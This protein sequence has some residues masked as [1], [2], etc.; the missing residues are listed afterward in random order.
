MGRRFITDVYDGGDQHDFVEVDEDG[1]TTGTV[2]STRQEKLILDHNSEMRALRGGTINHSKFGHHVASIP[3]ELFQQW[4]RT[5]PE[6]TSPDRKVRDAKL[7]ALI[8]DPDFKNVRTSEASGGRGRK[9]SGS[10][11]FGGL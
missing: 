3:I 2:Q 6:L 10:V 1:F 4:K 11:S 8:N 5:Y 9:R 7:I